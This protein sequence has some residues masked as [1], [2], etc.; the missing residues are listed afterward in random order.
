MPKIKTIQNSNFFI[1]RIMQDYCYLTLPVMVL[2]NTGIT[3]RS[4]NLKQL[5]TESGQFTN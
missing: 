5:K 4:H 3:L 2:T 1:K